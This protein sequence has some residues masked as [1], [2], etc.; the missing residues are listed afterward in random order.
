[1]VQPGVRTPE[2]HD[3]FLVRAWSVRRQPKDTQPQRVAQRLNLCGDSGAAWTGAVADGE[4][5]PGRSWLASRPR[6]THPGRRGGVATPSSSR[7]QRPGGSVQP[8]GMCGS[9]ARCP[10]LRLHLRGDVT[11]RRSRTS[12]IPIRVV[13]PARDTFPRT[14]APLPEYASAGRPSVASPQRRDGTWG[15]LY[16]PA[17]PSRDRAER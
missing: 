13:T 1:M 16:V 10:T 8:G 5:A 11:W 3:Q 4:A 2:P 15:I 17:V 6:G 7:L 12:R 9:V 14:A